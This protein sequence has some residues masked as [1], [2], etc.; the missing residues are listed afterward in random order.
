MPFFAIRLMLTKPLCD[1]AF[2]TLGPGFRPDNL[3]KI[4]L[5]LLTEVWAYHTARGPIKDKLRYAGLVVHVCTRAEPPEMA[6]SRIDEADL[7]HPFCPFGGCERARFYC[8]PRKR[9][10]PRLKRTVAPTWSMWYLHPNNEA[11]A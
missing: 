7:S 10:S 2:Y 8:A 4:L 3:L 1:A 6:T 9:C 11:P 5:R